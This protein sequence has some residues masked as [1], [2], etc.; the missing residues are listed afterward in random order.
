MSGDAARAR[1][2]Q[3]RALRPTLKFVAELGIPGLK[4][5]MDSV[6]YY[7]GPAR[8]PFLPLTDAQKR[9]VDEVLAGVAPAAA[10]RR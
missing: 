4:Y 3:Q 7:G 1:T 9:E 10:A 6:G 2:L 8:M 5:A